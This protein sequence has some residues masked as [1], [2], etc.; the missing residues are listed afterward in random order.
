VSSKTGSVEKE[1]SLLSTQLL[2]KA[3]R[4]DTDNLQQQQQLQQQK[5][6]NIMMMSIKASLL[7]HGVP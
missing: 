5:M 2:H 7:N 3:D 6:M 4:T 1:L